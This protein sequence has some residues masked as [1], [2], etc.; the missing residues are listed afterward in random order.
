MTTD[1]ERRLLILS[2]LDGAHTPDSVEVTA[3]CGCRSWIAPSGLALVRNPFAATTTVCMRHLDPDDL[4]EAVA[5][6]KFR[7]VP[8]SRAE[9]DAILGVAAVD[10]LFAQLSIREDDTTHDD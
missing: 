4:R 3:D 9:L 6:H 2:P 5:A 1:N 7:A 8:G 10:Q